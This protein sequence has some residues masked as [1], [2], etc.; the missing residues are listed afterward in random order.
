MT[1][2]R[3]TSNWREKWAPFFESSFCTFPAQL[4]HPFHRLFLCDW[5]LSMGQCLVV[6]RCSRCLS[7]YGDATVSNGTSTRWLSGWIG[8]VSACGAWSSL[9]KFLKRVSE[10]HVADFLECRFI[11]LFAWLQ[12][13]CQFTELSSILREFAS[14]CRSI[15]KVAQP[16]VRWAPTADRSNRSSVIAPRQA[17]MVASMA[18]REGDLGTLVVFDHALTC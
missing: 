3:A 7:A 14:A 1:R 18:A 13:R 11:A 5:D 8:P 9:A 12:W 4:A 10:S 15:F 16:A 17:S 6:L 2:F